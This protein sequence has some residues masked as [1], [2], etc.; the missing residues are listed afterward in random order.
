MLP[1]DAFL[2]RIPSFVDAAQSV[3]F[4]A[5]VFSA[6]AIEVSLDTIRRVTTEFR[7]RLGEASH[8]VHVNLF[9][10][11]WT[12]VDCLHVIRQ[13][14]ND[15][16]HTAPKLKEFCVKYEHASVLRNRMD[17]LKG[18]AKNVAAADQRPPVFGA[19]SYVY[20]PDQNIE[21]R[22]GQIV[23]TGGGIASLTAGRTYGSSGRVT[24]VNPC[25]RGLRLPVGGFKLEAFGESL[26]LDDAERDVQELMAHINERV[27]KQ[28][29][30]FAATIAE[31]E[32][33]PLDKLM[34]SSGGGL[35]AYV[36][37]AFD[38]QSGETVGI[39]W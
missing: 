27:E 5:M 8:T 28:A 3:H 29:L 35:F 4:E 10:H 26:E 30:D 31:K 21:R 23:I 11:A 33:V 36:E 19:L 24:F 39:E 14:I 32:N 2:R 25:G 15:P 13:V 22:G 18:N 38:S 12:I 16:K 20:I 34:A 1:S 37:F 9:L 7:E 6:D 17:H